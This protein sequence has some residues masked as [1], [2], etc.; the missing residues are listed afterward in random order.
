RQPGPGPVHRATRAPAGLV[1]RTAAPAGRLLATGQHPRGAARA[2]R[3]HQT[4]AQLPAP[5]SPPGAEP[6]RADQAPD[7]CRG[8]RGTVAACAGPALT[9]RE[10]LRHGWNAQA[11]QNSAGC[12]GRKRLLYSNGRTTRALRAA[13]EGGLGLINA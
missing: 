12:Y 5:A 11:R 3:P 1:G 13:E 7:P 2:W 9:S 10:R 8:H 4:M 6:V